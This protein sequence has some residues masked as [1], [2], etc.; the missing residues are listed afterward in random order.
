MSR[1]PN[2]T[3]PPPLEPL[4]LNPPRC[5][6]GCGSSSKEAWGQMAKM[7]APQLCVPARTCVVDTHTYTHAHTHTHIHTHARTHTNT[8]VCMYVSIVCMYRYIIWICIKTEWVH[9]CTPLMC[10]CLSL[11]RQR[12]SVHLHTY[13]CTYIL[14]PN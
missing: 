3:S 12:E 11:H 9:T 13:V 1:P 14:R 7:S 2:T 4:D 8:H 5:G 10:V 6:T